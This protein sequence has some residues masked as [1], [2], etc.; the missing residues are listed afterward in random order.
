LL[1]TCVLRTLRTV[2]LRVKTINSGEREKIEREKA[3]EEGKK[4]KK[5][6][7][8]KRE[9]RKERALGVSIRTRC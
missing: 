5:K 1:I 9:K 4:K 3:R 6:R 2:E 8:E 7:K